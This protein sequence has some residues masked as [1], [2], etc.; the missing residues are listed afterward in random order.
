MPNWSLVSY[1]LS[2]DPT[3]SDSTHG[4]STR[5]DSPR[6]IRVGVLELDGTV[7]A[8]DAFA[9]R[10]LL[11]VIDDWQ[12]IADDLRGLDTASLPI[13]ADA[14]LV[15]PLAYPRKIICAGELLRAPGRDGGAE[16]GS[17]RRAVLLPQAAHHDRHRPH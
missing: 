1:H 15:A 5:D 14:K 2:H 3:P 6:D 17:R 13:V 7:L 16:A 11:E 10:T 12:G 8:L 4:D 9:G